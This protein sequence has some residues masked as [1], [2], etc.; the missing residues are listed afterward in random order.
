VRLRT[1]I[2]A[3]LSVADAYQRVAE[4]LGRFIAPSS[5]SSRE[6]LGYAKDGAGEALLRFQHRLAVAPLKLANLC[7]SEVQ[8]PCQAGATESSSS[9]VH[10]NAF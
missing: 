4:E 9:G 3:R 5:S 2:G 8:T 10:G 6:T 1:L 7:K